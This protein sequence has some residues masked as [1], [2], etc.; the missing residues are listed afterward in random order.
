MG[1]T[2]AGPWALRAVTGRQLASASCGYRLSEHGNRIGSPPGPATPMDFLVGGSAPGRAGEHHH[3]FHAE[4]YVPLPACWA[5]R[6]RMDFYVVHTKELFQRDGGRGKPGEHF[7]HLRWRELSQGTH[8]LAGHEGE[9]PKRSGT[10]GRAPQGDKG[11]VLRPPLVGSSLSLTLSARSAQ[12]TTLSHSQLPQVISR[13][14]TGEVAP[15]ASQMGSDRR[16][17]HHRLPW[18]D[19]A[20]GPSPPRRGHRIFG[21]SPT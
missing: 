19:I 10:I 8:M 14:A 4:T 2:G 15:T 16:Q 5:R 7:R 6:V 11:S 3:W 18:L 12:P 13:R 21:E 9:P 20:D 17:A 1:S